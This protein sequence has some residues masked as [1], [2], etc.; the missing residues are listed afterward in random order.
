MKQVL[1]SAYGL[2]VK[3]AMVDAV[4]A[5]GGRAVGVETNLGVRYRGKAV[6]LCTGTFLKGLVHIGGELPR[7]RAGDFPA[8]K[9]P[10]RC[11][12]GLSVGR[13]K[14]VRPRA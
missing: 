12:L 3:Q 14:D 2:D 10:I 9:A 11:A 13:L 6:V 4:L 7:G 8:G 5:E 1:E